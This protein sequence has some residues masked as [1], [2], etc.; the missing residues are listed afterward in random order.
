MLSV[1]YFRNNFRD[2]S[3]NKKISQGKNRIGKGTDVC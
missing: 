1:N 3:E 2:R